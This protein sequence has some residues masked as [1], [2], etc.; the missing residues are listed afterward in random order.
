METIYELSR[1]VDLEY[2]MDMLKNEMGFRSLS[3]SDN[4]FGKSVG[5]QYVTVRLKKSGNL[6]DVVVNVYE[7]GHLNNIK[8]KMETLL[9]WE[10]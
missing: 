4:L 5:Q 10:N 8:T 3:M 2:G 9:I 6:I 1:T 7:D